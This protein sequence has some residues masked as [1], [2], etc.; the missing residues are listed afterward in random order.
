[1]IQCLRR[2]SLPL[3]LVLIFSAASAQPANPA[4]PPTPVRQPT[5]GVKVAP[6]FVMTDGNGYRGLAIDLWQETAADHGW[7]YH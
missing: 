4:E 1:M 2:T 6:P 7:S 5:V 3:M